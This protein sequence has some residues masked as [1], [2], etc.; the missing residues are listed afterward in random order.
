M[1][2]EA[3]AITVGQGLRKPQGRKRHMAQT[4]EAMAQALR[5]LPATLES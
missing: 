3:F 4:V 2:P 5:E 1:T